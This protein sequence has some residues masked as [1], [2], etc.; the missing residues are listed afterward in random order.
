MGQKQPKPTQDEIRRKAWL[1]HLEELND[2]I[3]NVPGD[4]EPKTLAEMLFRRG[5]TKIRL[6]LLEE[7]LPDLDDAI[8][9]YDSNEE[10]FFAR[11]YCR[12]MLLHYDQA[13]S[14]FE[15][16][17]L[18]KYDREFFFLRAV[19]KMYL[20]M[21]EEAVHDLDEAITSSSNEPEF[22]IT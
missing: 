18:C 8:S 11:G 1:S 13:I 10:I 9:R 20:N 5:D 2:R 22:L 14:D 12:Y 21:Y 15:Q 6:G 16:A 3:A 4:I 19:C 17:I 7:A